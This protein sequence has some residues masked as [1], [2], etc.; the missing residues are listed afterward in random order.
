[1]IWGTT[2]SWTNSLGGGEEMSG[3]WKER[4]EALSTEE[5][6]RNLATGNY[7]KPKRDHAESLIRKRSEVSKSLAEKG[8]V[9]PDA[10][11]RLFVRSDEDAK[12]RWGNRIMIAGIVVAAVV[13]LVVAWMSSG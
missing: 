10:L 12:S 7:G 5:L 11:L 4:M 8:R 1:M 13:A 2:G 9:V 6:E 3:D